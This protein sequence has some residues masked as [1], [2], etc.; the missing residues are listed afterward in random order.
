[1]YEL[2]RVIMAGELPRVN[3]A[4]KDRILLHLLNEDEQA[5]RFVVSPALTRPGIA[6]A[7][8]QHPPNVSRAMRNLLRQK[9]VSEHTRS[10]RGDDRR[11]K[12]WQLTESGKE[13][14]KIRLEKLGK[15]MVLIRDKE[16]GLL[17]VIADDVPARLQ[18]ELS[19]LQ[20]LLHAQ[21]E[22]V[23]TFGD[24]RFGLVK[25][26]DVDDNSL[27]PPGRLKLLAGAHATYHTAPPATR[28]VHGRKDILS[29]IT[30]WFSKGSPCLVVHGIAGIGKSTLIANWLQSE[31]ENQPH[32]S[33]CWYPCQPW[34]KTV[35]LAVS[36]LHRFGV[37][38]K[39]DPYQIMETLPLTPGSEI[40][41]D[42]WR[43]RLLAY[44]TDA[45]AIRERFSVEAGGPP[46]YWLIILDDIHHIVKESRDLLGA[47]LDISKKAP[48]R[49]V[50][51]SRTTLDVYDRRDVHTRSLVEELAL[52]GL[53]VDEV[54]K[55]L[56]NL[57]TESPSA[58]EIH[59][60]TGGHPLAMEL[61]ELYGNVTHGDWLKFLDEEIIRYMPEEEFEL[62]ATLAVSDKPIPWDVLA[63]SVDWDGNPPQ[64]LLEYGLLLDLEEGMWL[65]EALRERF[66]REVGS[67]QS[68]RKKKLAD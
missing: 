24:I 13:L 45:Q 49:L 64:R 10:I 39:H 37:N 63:K 1:L 19:I 36:L 22:G 47:L 23:L 31:I 40:D 58:E 56:E 68:E 28:T 5:D 4:V 59:R 32:L 65:H 26:K 33:I 66:L 50:M 53:S 11:Q 27:P 29:G 43:R 30:D 16:G 7:C 42:S 54:S 48:L 67:T 51:I 6:E 38:D 20:I 35:G 57:D 3:I 14:A 46:P 41:I 18:S 15:T 9:H 2:F 44:L 52:Q 17:E 21:H 61:L 55:W 25:K 8:A 62:L 34:D 12:T 60:L